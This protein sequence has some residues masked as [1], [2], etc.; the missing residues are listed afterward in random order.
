M[1]L[2]LVISLGGMLLQKLFA[3][4]QKDTY[5]PR[6]SDINVPAVTPGNPIMW[7]R[8]SMKVNTQL[9]WNSPLIETK[10]EDPQTGGGG[11]GGGGGPHSYSYKYSAFLALAICQGPIKQV[12]RIWANQKLL[13]ESPAALAHQQADYDAAYYSEL[14][15]LVNDEFMLDY[16]A[17]YVSA[18]F[19]AQNNFAEEEYDYG[20]QAEALTY[21]TGHPGSLPHVSVAIPAPDSGKVSALLDQM[22]SPLGKDMVYVHQKTRFDGMDVY[23]GTETQ[24]PST[25]LEGY[26]GVGNVPAFR[27]T[28]YFVIKNL[29]LEDF[30]NAIPQFQISILQ[31][32][33]SDVKL[34]DLVSDICVEAGLDESEFNSL[35]YIPQT[36][37]CKG[38]AA[39]QATSAR[40]LINNLQKV[41]PFDIAESGYK[42]FFNWINQRGTLVARR[43]DFGA[44]VD[45]DQWPN[46]EHITRGHDLDLPKR[47]NLKYQEPARNFSAN[48]V[49]ATRQV[50]QA[51]GVEDVDVSISLDRPTAKKYAEEQLAL[52]FTARRGYKIMLPRK[53]AIIEPGDVI[54]VPYKDEADLYY[55]LRMIESAV[56]VNG[57][58]EASFIDHS[59]HIELDALA[60]SDLETSEAKA[61]E[62]GP[63]FTY[64][65]DMPLLTD[66]EPDNVGYYAVLATSRD[67]WSGGA[68][69]VDLGGVADVGA[70]GDIHPVTSGSN[71][72]TAV[73]NKTKTPTGICMGVLAPCSPGSWDYISTIT[74]RLF[75][76]ADVLFNAARYDLLTQ[77]INVC[78]IGGEVIQFAN[79]RSLGNG[80]WELDTFLR[81]LRGTEYAINTHGAGEGFIKLSFSGTKRISHSQN[82]LNR[83]GTYKGVT[84]NDDP[85]GTPNV[86]FTD[87]GN[88]LRPRAVQLIT[89]HRDDVD[90]VAIA[91]LPRARQNGNWLSG[92]VVLDQPAEA[93]EIDVVVASAVVKTYAL[94]AVR[95]W[96]YTA[97]M[98]TSDF[99]APA[100]VRL[101]IYQIGQIIGRGFVASV[102]V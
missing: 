27:G 48:T 88:S 36:A 46:S 16:P 91:W 41:F 42:L 44:H 51:M 15:R 84:L 29:Q 63:T 78:V 61:S 35:A 21:I 83:D 74:V 30:G 1:I 67:G 69:L 31:N 28:A 23:L 102:V 75:N 6:V 70:F 2:P 85:S 66:H 94:G 19:F 89:Q 71:F 49:F 64:L 58:I 45:T 38:F 72:Y 34:V 4:K 76:L 11:K 33:G 68:L 101:N 99:G 92:P 100:V 56:G 87:T 12:L 24:L 47:L 54:H 62:T 39:Q 57:V 93:Y 26:L 18:F 96:A 81:G 40:D 86:H 60:G 3:P 53:Y 73:I 7:V 97:A 20:T 17:G 10:V 82:Y 52:R 80:V 32:D 98:Q 22:L 43:E 77:A 14:D 9:I 37:T 79:A 13:W 50:T 8:G 90:N 5:G 59:F 25:V 95:S 65:L 55:G